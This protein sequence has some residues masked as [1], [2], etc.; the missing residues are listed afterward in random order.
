MARGHTALE[1]TGTNWDA[2][3]GVCISWLR[4][5]FADIQTLPAPCLHHPGLQNL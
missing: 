1:G 4:G 5:G 2:N 3:P